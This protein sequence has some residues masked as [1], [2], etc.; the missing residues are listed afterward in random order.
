MKYIEKV[1]D[2]SSEDDIEREE[3]FWEYI[4]NS[5]LLHQLTGIYCY[6]SYV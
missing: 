3:T 5:D 2:E 6:L 4:K 1:V